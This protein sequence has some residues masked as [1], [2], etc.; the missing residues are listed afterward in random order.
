MP[1]PVLP[2]ADPLALPPNDPLIPGFK[3]DA[4]FAAIENNDN[5]IGCNWSIVKD[6][7]NACNV[8]ASIESALTI[9]APGMAVVETPDAAAVET[10][11]AGAVVVDAESNA[12]GLA[13]IPKIIPKAFV[14][15]RIPFESTL[16]PAAP[17]FDS[18]FRPGTLFTAANICWSPGKFSALFTADADDAVI[19]PA[20][21]DPEAGT[22]VV[23]DPSRDPLNWNDA[24][25]GT[26]F[27]F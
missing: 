18:K 10:P 12:K 7:T 13:R 11:D 5:T 20:T 26:Q 21:V 22:A 4:A 1:L 8:L 25:A 9:D 19:P 17:V 27:T 15:A 16:S 6:S 24:S 2:L 14:P 3:F 23:N